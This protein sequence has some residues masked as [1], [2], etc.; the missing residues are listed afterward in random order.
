MAA[1]IL[2][3]PRLNYL[4]KALTNFIKLPATKMWLDYDAVVDVIYVHFEEKPAST[5]SEMTDEGIIIDYRDQA[6]VGLAVLDAS[7][8]QVVEL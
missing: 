7:Q 3:Q 1:Q 5:H 2:E 4:F 8:R 6:L